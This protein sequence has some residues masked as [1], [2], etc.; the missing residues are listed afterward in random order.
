MDG[1]DYT[2]REQYLS[3]DDFEEVFDMS[4][5]EFSNL[6]KWRQQEMKKKVGLF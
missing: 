4:K 1:I 2:Q 3:P 6:R 5:E